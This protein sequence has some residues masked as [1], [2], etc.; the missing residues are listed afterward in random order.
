MEVGTQLGLV[1]Q[2]Q[3]EVQEEMGEM[4]ERKE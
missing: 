4:G 1:T 3:E 2:E